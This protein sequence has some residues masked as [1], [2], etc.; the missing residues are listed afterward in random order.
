MA[1]VG[2]TQLKTGQRPVIP[3]LKTFKEGE[4][5]FKEGDHGREMYV[6]K[7]GEIK[8]TRASPEG[9]VELAR[10]KTGAILGEMS[11]L[12]NLPRSASAIA[13]QTSKTTVIDELVFNSVMKNVPPWLTSIVRIITS[14]LR[15]ANKRVGQSV[16][17]N[18]EAGIASLLNL[19]L[20]ANAKTVSNMLALE[21]NFVLTESYYVCHLGKSA[22][23][24]VL[25]DLTKRQIIEQAKDASN[26]EYV[27]IMDREVLAL[28]VEFNRLKERGRSFIELEIPDNEV[29]LLNNVVYVSQK[30]G[31]ETKNGTI[32][33]MKDFIQDMASK[34][35]SGI[36]KMLGSLQRR[37]IVSIFPSADGSDNV[38]LFE[39]ERLSRIRKIK[40]WIDRFRMDPKQ[41]VKK[42]P[43][44]KK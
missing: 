7:E 42:E 41:E 14:R 33:P 18:R 23:E 1:I 8:I 39:K 4:T 26:T 17:R 34:N 28:F 27:F 16:L 44:K 25:K 38:I 29:D 37:E 36:E 21:L 22:T 20:E 6:I 11:L 12:D 40:E 35:V 5:L 19:L 43:E 10:L 24:T 9:E 30:S 32:L 3:N 31:K 15:D 13:S 2:S